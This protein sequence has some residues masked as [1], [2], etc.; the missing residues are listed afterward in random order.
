MGTYLVCVTTSE[1]GYLSFFDTCLKEL[2]PTMWLLTVR[3]HYVDIT[4][5]RQ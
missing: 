1:Y 2:A 5:V 3:R 4:S